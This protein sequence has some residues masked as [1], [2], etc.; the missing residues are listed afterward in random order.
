MSGSRHGARGTD[1]GYAANPNQTR[2][3]HELV[4]SL[5]RNGEVNEDD[6]LVEDRLI[7]ALGV[8][9]QSVREALQQ[10]ASEG[11]VVRQRRS[12]TRV[13]QKYYH[14]PLDDIVPWSCPPGFMVR[15]TDN[16]VVRST[17]AIR[18]RLGVTDSEVGL[19][20]HVFED[21]VD[22]AIRPI[23]VRI[24]YYRAQYTQ[25]QRWD[26]CPTLAHAFAHVFGVELGRIDTV[27]DAVT[28]DAGTA[29]LLDLQVGAPVLFREQVLRGVDG[30]VYE[31]TFSH[32]R[33][34]RVSFPMASSAPGLHADLA[35]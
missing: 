16:R 27:V 32:Y 18:E 25:P 28:A 23:G 3:T 14:V 35:S 5:I 19:V 7:R 6:K 30:I 33:A 31:Y 20:E 4:R 26:A 13:S 21:F 22:R 34:D 2:R 24:A 10:L 29:E 1:D 11:L 15:R 12:G 17:P 8:T 9:R